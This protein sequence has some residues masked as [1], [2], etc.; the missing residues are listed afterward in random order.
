[1]AIENF[2]RLR[3]GVPVALHFRDHAIVDRVITDP[4]F[5]VKRT[6]KG[7]LFLVDEQDG[8]PV[9]KTFSILSDRLAGDFSGDLEG[10]AYRGYIYVIVKDAPGTVPPR[11]LERR[12]R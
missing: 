3:P 5:G 11:I 7:L 1:M 8:G 2:V 4:T 10:K 6:V 12:P 9:D